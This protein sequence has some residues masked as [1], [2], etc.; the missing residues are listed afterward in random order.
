MF[1]RRVRHG[2]CIS[3]MSEGSDQPKFGVKQD[4]PISQAEHA[5][6]QSQAPEQAQ[7]LASQLVSQGSGTVTT[8][9]GGVSEAA[10]QVTAQAQTAL[11]QTLETLGV[12]PEVV[13]AGMNLANDY[14]QQGMGAAATKLA[15]LLGKQALPKADYTLEVSDGPDA[16]WQVRR[17]HLVEALSEP[18]ALTLDLVTDDLDADTDAMLGASIELMIERDILARHVCGIIHQVEYLGV[19]FD[20]L[21]LRVQVGPALHLLGQRVDTRL[22]QDASVPDVVREV[23]AA[24]LGDYDRSVK[25]D[26][27]TA[28]YQ[29]REY[30]VQYRESDLDFVHRLLEEEGITYWFDHTSGKGKEVLVLADSNDNYVDI[31]TIDAQPSLP[32]IVNQP[33]NAEVE[34]VQQLEWSRELTSTAVE[35]RIFDWQDPNNPISATSTT[36][37]SGDSDDRGRVREVYH[38]GH[39]V[40]ANPQPRTIRKLRHLRQRDNVAR[41][42]GNVTGLAPG[43]KF[44]ITGH[45]RAELDQEYLIRRIVHSGEC[46]EVIQGEA[47]PDAARYENHFECMVCDPAEPFRPPNLT[48]RPRIYGPQTAIVTGPDGEEIH[49]DEHGR[50]KVLFSWDRVHRPGDDT[51]M[52]IRVAHHWAGPGFGT[53]FVPRIGMEVVVEFIEGDPAKPLVNGCVYN[54]ANSISVKPA[55]NKTQSTI[56]TRSSPNSEGYN[57]IL[58]E[59]AA[60]GEKIVLHAQKDFNETVENDHSTTVHNNQ[61]ITVDVDQ[62]TTVH[63][64]QTITVDVDQT[65]TVSGN[66]TISV[67]GNRSVSVSGNQSESISGESTLS[68]QKDRSVTVT[69]KRSATV[70]GGEDKISV[71][72]DFLLDA[73]NKISLTAPTEIRLTCGEASIVMTPSRIE[74]SVEGSML[75]LDGTATLCSKDLSSVQLTADASMNASTGAWLSLT[76]GAV[77][78]SDVGKSQV[79]LDHPDAPGALLCSQTTATLTGGGEGGASVVAEAAGLNAGGQ[80]VDIAAM[81]IAT[82]SGAMVKIN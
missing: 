12:P 57:E 33:D 14:A 16:V 13:S 4:L 11:G 25:L 48:R 8:V 49:T 3:E 19:A 76:A 34:S 26:G 23:L 2:T 70:Q 81:G 36:G 55:E 60:G 6:A 44:A 20:R 58:F 53:F 39:F 71:T 27:L 64:N 45:Q 82:I 29:P 10:K 50:V 56:R 17:M 21:Q 42:V 37:G 67:T 35:Q 78:S 15:N 54:G 79:S 5:L 9:L 18:Y 1:H 52:W 43:R 74:L 63:N 75:I 22:W 40:E 41:G 51:S 24:A 62:A 65:T 68:V 32:I 28:T 77:L 46:P 66:Q 61:T 7:A 73:S 31:E 80:K 47:P 30:I 38:H 69:G 72:G 59:D